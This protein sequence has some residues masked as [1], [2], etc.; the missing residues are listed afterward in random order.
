MTG[1]R[2]RDE[3][4]G[5]HADVELVPRSPHQ[6]VD[7]RVRSTGE[8]RDRV[9]EDAERVLGLPLEPEELR[10]GSGTRAH[11]PAEPVVDL[12]HAADEQREDEQRRHDPQQERP[13]DRSDQYQENARPGT[14]R[15]SL[16]TAGR[17]NGH[18]CGLAA[19]VSYEELVR[20]TS[21][22]SSASTTMRSPSWISPDKTRIASGSWISRWISRRSGRAPNAG[23]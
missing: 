23:S 4:H 9:P 8:Q 1:Q 6:L 22:S 3:G 13:S 7:R 21:V 14:H 12:G 11:G 16:G 19:R 18:L 17:T 20:N 15:A 5:E 2:R 10:A